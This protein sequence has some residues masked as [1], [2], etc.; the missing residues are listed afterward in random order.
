MQ[1]GWEEGGGA[2]KVSF[3]WLSGP[4]NSSLE[5]CILA[6]RQTELALT[7]FLLQ[8]MSH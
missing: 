7:P 6:G 3:C 8:M 5:S 1:L 2:G 4:R